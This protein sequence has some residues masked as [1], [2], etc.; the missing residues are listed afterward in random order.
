MANTC[1]IS[2]RVHGPEASLR[3]LDAELAKALDAAA[4]GDEHWA[5]C[6]WLHMGLDGKAARE[7]KLGQ[8]ACAITAHAVHE[9]VLYADMESKWHPQLKP[10]TDFV[11]RYAPDCSVTFFADEPMTNLYE[12]NEEKPHANVL[13]H[14]TDT[15]EAAELADWVSIW[16]KD[17]LLAAMAGK[18][19]AD[20]A[21][22]FDEVAR[23]FERAYP[24]EIRT[25]SHRDIG[26]YAK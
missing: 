8:C 11:A 25:Y 3:A 18:L 7:G 20:P 22:G 23:E 4:P 14:G 5:G 6:L 2:L 16:E 26:D 21:R 10:V 1:F 17:A 15:P 19:H 13:F 12:T 9:G 24:V